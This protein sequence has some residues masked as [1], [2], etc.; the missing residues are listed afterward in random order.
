MSSDIFERNFLFFNVLPFSPG[1][2]K[3]LAADAVDY[4]KQTGNDLVL[5]CMTLHPQGFPAMK[6]AEALLASYRALKAELDG[7]GVRLG[8]LIQS[9]LG[10]WPRVDKDE[11]PWT[12][13]VNSEGILTRFCPLDER[14]RKYIFDVAAMFAREKPV[15]ILGDDDIRSFSQGGAEC[16]CELHTAEF[17]RRTGNHFTPE[18]YRA[19]V[20]AS[21]Q[22]DAVFT[23][24]DTLRR[25]LFND[26]ASL[27]REAIDSVDPSI[28]AGSC[29]PGAEIRFASETARR[30]AAKDQ[31]VV[32]RL[33]NTLY[34]ERSAKDFP[35]VVS[36]TMGYQAA[37]PSVDIA[38]DE[39]DTFPHTL[40][41]RSSVGMHAKLFSSIFCGLRGSKLWLVNCRKMGRPVHK[42]YTKILA[43]YSRA[44]QALA[45]E[46]MKTRLT[47]V[48]IP[49]HRNFPN[50]HPGWGKRN[51]EY[52]LSEPTLGSR[53]FGVLGIPYQC[54]FEL[55]SPGVY[56]IAGAQA[57]GRFR[58]EELKT[59]L[60]GRLLL[61][62]PAAVAV[63]ERGFAGELGLTACFEEFRYNR[64]VDPATETGYPITKE[65]NV[66]HFKDLDPKA[67]VM[68]ELCYSPYAGS[69]EREFAAPG[70]VFFRNALGGLVCST[71]FH[72][73]V[74][75]VQYN[76]TRKEW[77]VRILERLNGGRLPAVCQD[78]QEILVLTRAYEDGRVLCYICNLNF[79]P[80]ETVTLRCGAEPARVEELTPGGEWRELSFR[81]EGENIVLDRSLNCYETLIVR[82]ISEGKE[83]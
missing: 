29:M 37:H 48:I 63:C 32:M 15:F 11:E 57:I 51:S 80:M 59:L 73:D 75:Y 24:F 81:K 71:A 64:E 17:N 9:I 55:D 16:F 74:S 33:G 47:G 79:D 77:Y 76:E 52:F 27:I 82:L 49:A 28:P 1:K 41:S 35:Y 62:G 46:V 26:V 66:P 23:A 6:K 43:K 7:T 13:S 69:P 65:S 8:L 58:D 50:W 5:Y 83:K 25:E 42:N 12:R 30:F 45:G 68:T 31:P 36:R 44:Y 56:A 21:Q 53:M 60:S 14:Y 4:M 19:A 3:E 22:G 78:L 40:Y 38:M 18:E 72:Q 54:K 10:H 20:K 67:E 70:T 61:D 2:E 39:S 34:L